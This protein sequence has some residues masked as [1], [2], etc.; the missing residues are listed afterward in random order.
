MVEKR[1]AVIHFT[2]GSKL[3]LDFPKQT[4]DANITQKLKKV[5]DNP[6]LMVEA[7]GSLITIPMSSIKYIQSYPTP[8]VLPDFVIR[9]A[10]IS[11]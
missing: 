5:L 9:D 6:C 2:G 4:E 7:D 11:D 3:T 1:Y 10:S 8:N